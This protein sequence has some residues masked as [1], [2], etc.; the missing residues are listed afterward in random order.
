[1]AGAAGAQSVPA[2]MLTC[3]GKLCKAG[4]RCAMDGTC[5]AFLGA[6]FSNADK[7]ES[8]DAYCSSIGAQCA[9][10]S[11]NDNG[12]PATIGYSWVS[13]PASGRASCQMSGSPATNSFDPCN[14]PIWLSP[15]K[16]LDDVI[17]CCC[18]G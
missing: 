13:Y 18:K 6:C 14:S 12:T 4:G 15:T 11:C 5:P 3:G 1:M 8:C 7:I 9:A 16:P 10:K 17:R 2:G